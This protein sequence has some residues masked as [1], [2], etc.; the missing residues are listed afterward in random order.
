MIN[1]N[2]HVFYGLGRNVDYKLV[3]AINN[4]EIDFINELST[5]SQK[6][7]LTSI[8]NG[9]KMIWKDENDSIHLV[10]H[11]NIKAFEIDKIKEVYKYTKQFLNIQNFILVDQTHTFKQAYDIFRMNRLSFMQ[12]CNHFRIKTIELKSE[13]Y[14][15][16]QIN[17]YSFF[18]Q[19]KPHQKYRWGRLLANQKTVKELL[20]K[21]CKK[22][23]LIQKIEDEHIF[24]RNKQDEIECMIVVVYAPS[25]IDTF[26]NLY[27]KI[28][29]KNIKLT[30]CIVN[31]FPDGKYEFDIFRLTEESYL[32]H[33]NR[34]RPREIDIYKMNKFRTNV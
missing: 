28:I 1:I 12:H 6:Y 30:F 31:Q 26:I 19:L 22:N 10:L 15:P 24:W 13:N 17:L 27:S 21:E 7:S 5:L 29:E 34:V 33:C 4:S 9:N 2:D 8:I 3:K 25:N 16:M 18:D 11:F 20:E 32:E 14:N 23:N